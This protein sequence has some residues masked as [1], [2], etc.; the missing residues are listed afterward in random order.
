M[1]ALQFAICNLQFAIILFAPP[2]IRP[3]VNRNHPF[4]GQQCQSQAQKDLILLAEAFSFEIFFLAPGKVGQ[5]VFV[6]LAQIVGFGAG[7]DMWRRPWPGRF[8]S[9]N[10]D[11]FSTN[12]PCYRPLSNTSVRRSRRAWE[13]ERLRWNRPSPTV[14]ILMPFSAACLAA[15]SAYDSW[16]SPSVISTIIWSWSA[17]GGMASIA[18]RMASPISVPPTRRAAGIYLVEHRAEEIRRR[19]SAEP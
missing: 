12:V 15:S 16:S 8:V 14:K 18:L 19:S 1:Q 2:S 6:D 3:A 9:A 4:Q 5:M 10:P 13:C 17:R 11:S 7:W